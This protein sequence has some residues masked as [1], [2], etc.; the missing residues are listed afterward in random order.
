M[1]CVFLNSTITKYKGNWQFRSIWTKKNEFH[2]ISFHFIK[3]WELGSV[4]HLWYM[5]CTWGPCISWQDLPQLSCCSKSGRV[6]TQFTD[7]WW[8]LGRELC[9]LP[10]QG[11]FVPDT[12][13]WNSTQYVCCF[14]I[15]TWMKGGIIH[16][17]AFLWYR[18]I[19]LW[20]ETDPI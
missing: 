7:G 8:W 18:S 15:E 13:P 11:N 17:G 9:F 19:H 2:L 6:S 12:H 16:H 1:V 3:V 5:V 10:R 20:K 4:L 14:L